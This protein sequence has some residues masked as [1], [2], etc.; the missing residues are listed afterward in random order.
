[1][2]FVVLELELWALEFWSLEFGVWNYPLFGLQLKDAVP[3][4]VRR[5][6]G[7]EAAAFQV[8]GAQG[9]VGMAPDVVL[10]GGQGLGPLSGL[11]GFD[12]GVEG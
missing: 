2:E 8:H 12:D 6:G 1:M 3:I 10:G 7:E 5:S 4:V 9:V 11:V